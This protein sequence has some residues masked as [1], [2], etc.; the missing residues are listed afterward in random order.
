VLKETY[1]AILSKMREKHPDAYFIVV[2]RTAASPLSPSWELLNKAKA[3]KWG[4]KKYREYFISEI[5]SNRTA[6][7]A[8]KYIKE[9]SKRQD[10]YLVCY[11]KD[12]KKCHRSILIEMINELEV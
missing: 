9:I 6:R 12:A 7:E 5:E 3:D 10:V 4:F 1:L 8:M 11:E 2:T